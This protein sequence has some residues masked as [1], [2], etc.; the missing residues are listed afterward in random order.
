M[1]W[2][3]KMPD[4]LMYLSHDFDFCYT[5]LKLMSHDLSHDF[6]FCYTALKLMSH[7]LSH[8]FDFCYTALKL[9]SHGSLSHD[10]DLFCYT[11]I[12]RNLYQCLKLLEWPSVLHRK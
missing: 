4:V 9:M 1:A 8:D 3:D 5:A 6:D 11:A 7:D 12:R 2:Q 10:F